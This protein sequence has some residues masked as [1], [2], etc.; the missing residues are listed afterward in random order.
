MGT[1]LVVAHDR[2]APVRIERH[3][4]I[5]GRCA[6]LPSGR[7]HWIAAIS[8][9]DMTAARTDRAAIQKS[10]SSRKKKCG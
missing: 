6:A 2:M 1:K 7:A 9:N 5:P 3:G 10:R 8:S 4:G